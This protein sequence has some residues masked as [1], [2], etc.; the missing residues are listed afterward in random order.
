MCV[1]SILASGFFTI[2]YSM[3]WGPEK[4]MDWLTTFLLSFF[5]SVII[6]QPVKVLVLIPYCD[7]LHINTQESEPSTMSAGIPACGFHILCA[8]KA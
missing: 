8:E 3:E 4:S 5:Q 2:L 1:L 6:V 7:L